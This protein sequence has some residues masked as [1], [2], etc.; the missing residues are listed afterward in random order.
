M[1]FW[2]GAGH[3]E[4]PATLSQYAPL[5]VARQSLFG[6]NT[7]EISVRARVRALPYYGVFDHV[8]YRVYGRHIVLS[9][10]VVHPELRH[11][12]EVAV[13][14]IDEGLHVSNQIRDLTDSP[15]ENEIR[16]AIFV[17]IYTNR[18]MR[19]YAFSAEAPIH[20]VVEADHV[21]LEGEVS[22]D[23]D[24]QLAALLARSIRGVRSVDNQLTVSH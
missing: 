10:E 3:S 1:V 7:L 24:R 21:M 20:I 12:A 19:P 8:S 11:D 15:A 16:K 9:G 6:M 2:C 23:Y 17:A 18:E 5:S 13:R 14:E 22:S 4:W